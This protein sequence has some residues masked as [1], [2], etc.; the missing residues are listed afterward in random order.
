VE[1]HRG[2]RPLILAVALLAAAAAGAPAGAA[3]DAVGGTVD[4]SGVTI[5]IV[6]WQG[7]DQ[8]Y[9]TGSGG[10]TDPTGCDWAIIPA[11]LGTPPPSD[12][13]P[14]RPDAYLGLLT[15][16]G[17]GVRL[18]WVGDGDVV[19]LEAEARRLVEAYVAR[20]A[21]PRL[22]VHANPV[23]CGLVG[24]ESWFWATGW[25]GRPVVDRIEALGV[26]VD[27]RID[28]T[29]VRWSFGDG[30]ATAGGV[31]EA[32]PGRS[33]IHHVFTEHGTRTVTVGFDWRPRY[34]IAGT[35]WIS[36]PTIPVA[37]D[38]SYRVREAQAVLTG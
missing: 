19:D 25:D 9:A 10:G 3:E 38:R 2:R 5:T 17:V 29:E 14:Y 12:I 32:P 4:P 6:R 18:Q 33:S 22:A 1:G 20:V 37:A 34:R 21:V 7:Q 26:A 35:D 27:V 23:P 15:C 30:R 36:L 16:D 24:V 28:P 31:G 11:P 13:G 8:V